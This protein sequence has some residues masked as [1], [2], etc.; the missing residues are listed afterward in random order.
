M[1][2]IA[3]DEKQEA[4]IVKDKENK[5]DPTHSDH[6]FDDDAPKNDLKDQKSA[7]HEKILSARG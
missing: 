1:P 4:G 5:D 3:K 2:A 6:D 7:H